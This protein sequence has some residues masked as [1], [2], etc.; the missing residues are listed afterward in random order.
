MRII[1]HLLSMQVVGPVVADPPEQGCVDDLESLEHSW[2]MCGWHPLGVDA[3]HVIIVKA[4]DL[5]T[6]WNGKRLV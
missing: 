2:A 6:D 1:E 5:E 4:Y 3:V